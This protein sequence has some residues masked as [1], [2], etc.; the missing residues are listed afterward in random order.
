MEFVDE[1]FYL[2]FNGFIQY[3]IMYYLNELWHYFG[4]GKEGDV[5]VLVDSLF[6]IAFLFVEFLHPDHGQ[7]WVFEKYNTVF[8]KKPSTSTI[9]I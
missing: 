4:C 1:L 5:I 2:F 9:S 3:K 6:G 8:L 7:F